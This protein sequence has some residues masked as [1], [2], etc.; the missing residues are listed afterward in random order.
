MSKL[1]GSSRVRRTAAAAVAAMSAGAAVIAM[2]GTAQAATLTIR[3]PVTGTTHIAATDSSMDLGPGTLT[4]TVDDQAPAESNVTATLNLPPAVGEFKEFGIVP[5]SVKTTFIQEGT[6]TGSIDPGTGAVT[7]TARV[8]LQLSDLK[9]A[10]LPVLVGSHCK[11]KEPVK[12]T[13]KSGDDWHVLFGGTLT[14]TYTIPEFKDCLLATSLINLIVPG[15][16]NTITLKLGAGT[17]V[18]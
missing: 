9:V 15:S 5:V 18:P 3:Y 17:V 14:G 10:G 11:T 8:T 4:S 16:G 1:I 6:A 12:I 2:P 7:T 13:V